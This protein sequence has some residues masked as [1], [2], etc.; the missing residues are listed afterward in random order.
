MLSYVRWVQE[1]LYI[2]DVWPDG[3]AYVQRYTPIWTTTNGDSVHVSATRQAPTVTNFKMQIALY[4]KHHVI[5]LVLILHH[6]FDGAMHGGHF[7]VARLPKSNYR[8]WTGSV[9]K[10]ESMRTRLS[11]VMVDIDDLL[12][13]GTPE[14]LTQPSPEWPPDSSSEYVPSSGEQQQKS[15]GTAPGPPAAGSKQAPLEVDSTG[16]STGTASQT[17]GS[18]LSQI[19]GPEDDAESI[20][21]ILSTQ[22][23]A[24]PA[25]SYW[26]ATSFPTPSSPLEPE[27]ERLLINALVVRPPL[28]DNPA[29]H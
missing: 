1:P 28:G 21:S 19:L 14:A 7:T 18:S 9:A 27:E 24:T 3:T 11:R 2:M 13:G 6:S 29:R 25:T 26:H 8:E 4:K 15:D 17:A 22:L 16:A 23:D 5:P 20:A 12:H 10:Q